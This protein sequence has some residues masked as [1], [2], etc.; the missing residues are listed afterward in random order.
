M[1]INHVSNI[2]KEMKDKRYQP[3]H[4]KYPSKLFLATETAYSYDEWME[5][6]NNNYLIGYFIW[7]AF[8]YLGEIKY[9]NPEHVWN[10]GII[11]FC[12]FPKPTYYTTKSFWSSKPTAFLTIDE[13][14]PDNVPTKWYKIKTTTRW[15]WPNNSMQKVSCYTNCDEVELFL[16]G[17][18]QGV[19]KT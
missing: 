12:G 10:R 2:T 13:N 7:V 14:S 4:E 9:P 11:D 16:N 18:S 15:N 1:A 17:K 6:K 3:Y 8:D 5:V 19:K